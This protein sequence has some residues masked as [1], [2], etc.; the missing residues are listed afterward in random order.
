VFSS[1][2]GFP[3]INTVSLICDWFIFQLIYLMLNCKRTLTCGKTNNN[4]NIASLFWI[5]CN[6]P[7]HKEME[8]CW[9]GC[10]ELYIGP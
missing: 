3:R 8:F 6:S 9:M 4:Y 10:L 2:R 1:P 7:L 5:E